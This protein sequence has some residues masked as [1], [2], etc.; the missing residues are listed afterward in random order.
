MS[1]GLTINKYIWSFDYFRYLK[2]HLCIRH[3]LWTSV[4]EVWPNLF[5]K[6]LMSSIRGCIMI[7]VFNTY[8]VQ[9]YLKLKS[10]IYRRIL[11]R[12]WVICNGHLFI[13]SVKSKKKD[14]DFNFKIMIFRLFVFLF[15]LCLVAITIYWMKGQ[16]K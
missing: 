4:N 9:P 14:G 16:T 13:H 3:F 7:Y 8:L 2:L 6:I 10:Y 1:F 15:A 12:L 5:H 11:Q